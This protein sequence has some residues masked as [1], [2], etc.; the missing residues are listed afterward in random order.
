MLMEKI[1]SAGLI[2]VNQKSGVNRR[3]FQLIYDMKPNWL[4]FKE[5]FENY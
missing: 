1:D 5:Q 3:N 2:D 4:S